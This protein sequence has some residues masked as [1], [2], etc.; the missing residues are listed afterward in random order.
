MKFAFY[1]NLLTTA[2]LIMASFAAQATPVTC[3]SIM[4]GRPI[5]SFNFD[6]TNPKQ[7]LYEEIIGKT[8][9]S[10]NAQL[11]IQYLS[12]HPLLTDLHLS[13][14]Y[15]GTAGVSEQY[16]LKA[17]TQMVFKELRVQEANFNWQRINSIKNIRELFIFML[18]VHDL[19]KAKSVAKWIEMNKG[20]APRAGRFRDATKYQYQYTGPLVKEI[21]KRLGFTQE[22]IHLVLALIDNDIIGEVAV[23][24]PAR[25]HGLSPQQGLFQLR[26]SA[27]E[28]GLSL[29]DY[30]ALKSFYFILDA[31][32]YPA[33]SYGRYYGEDAEPQVFYQNL[34]GLIVPLSP[35]YHALVDLINAELN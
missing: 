33:L 14:L 9:E 34:E 28:S 6:I 15:D 25:N 13:V 3:I 18:A 12:Q 10:V 16:S 32:S 4:Q 24:D 1:I 8:P 29:A 35:H 22:E 30:F 21:M 17:H 27:K 19:G 11:I 26:E 5:Y 31:S 20:E 2:A 7:Q 23:Y